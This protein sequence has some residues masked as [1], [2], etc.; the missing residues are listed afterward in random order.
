MLQRDALAEA[1]LMKHRR[2]DGHS[3]RRVFGWQEFGRH[4]LDHFLDHFLGGRLIAFL[5]AIAGTR[6]RFRFRTA[7][8]IMFLVA[9]TV[10]EEAL[11]IP[12]TSPS[13]RPSRPRRGE[14]YALSATDSFRP[15]TTSSPPSRPS[16]A[17][18]RKVKD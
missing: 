9:R 18:L 12:R 15:A 2:Q 7:L 4:F 13:S 11:T 8:P 6:F 14:P 10:P 16:S 5:A 3:F 1:P 17:A